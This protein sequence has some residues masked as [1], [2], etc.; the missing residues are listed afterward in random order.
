[1]VPSLRAARAQRRAQKQKQKRRRDSG[2]LSA[3][4]GAATG[5]AGAASPNFGHARAGAVRGSIAPGT[6]RL[7]ACASDSSTRGASCPDTRFSEGLA[8][9]K[10]LILGG[11][12]RGA[13]FVVSS[14]SLSPLESWPR[15]PARWRRGG[16]RWRRRRRARR[17][18]EGRAALQSFGFL[19]RRIQ[20]KKDSRLFA[21]LGNAGDWC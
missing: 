10:L 15:T 21:F 11:G 20:E 18:A 9:D 6:A 12:K 14:L 5:R 13:L 8:D 7:D 19:R 3:R 16:R 1:M 17:D 2:R 4:V